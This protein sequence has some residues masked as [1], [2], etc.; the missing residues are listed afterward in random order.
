MREKPNGN[1][2]KTNFPFAFLSIFIIF[3]CKNMKKAI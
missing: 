1:E 2:K 3:A